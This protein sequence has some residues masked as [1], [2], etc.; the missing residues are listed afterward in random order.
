MRH[1]VSRLKPLLDGV[2]GMIKFIGEVFDDM[3]EITLDFVWDIEEFYAKGI[4]VNY[5]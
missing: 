5:N 4:N 3:F 1:G 2:S